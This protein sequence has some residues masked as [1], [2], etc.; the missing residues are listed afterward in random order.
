MARDRL[1]AVIVGALVTFFLFDAV[2]APRGITIPCSSVALGDSLVALW[3]RGQIHH[4]EYYE[5]YGEAYFT[6]VACDDETNARFWVDFSPSPLLPRIYHASVTFDMELEADAAEAMWRRLSFQDQV[7]SLTPSVAIYRSSLP[8]EQI[9]K[10]SQIRSDD[11]RWQATRYVLK[12]YEGRTLIDYLTIS[13]MPEAYQVADNSATASSY[14]PTVSSPYVI[15]S[16][17]NR[18]LQL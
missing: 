10:G 7:I 8:A 4:A 13:S 2:S 18:K 16:W 15:A 3:A 9:V 5:T 1:A 14:M 11:R 6:S 17:E 12:T